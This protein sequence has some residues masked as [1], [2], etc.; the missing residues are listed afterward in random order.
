VRLFGLLVLSS[1]F[2]SEHRVQLAELAIQHRLP[3]MFIFKT[4]VEVGGLM[5]YGVD[6]AAMYRRTGALVAR[7]LKGAKPADL[8]VEQGTKFLFAVNLKTAR[9]L[10]VTLPAAILLRADEVIE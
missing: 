9:A 8:P 4:Y 1:P 10:G 5:S 7:I 3:F 6:N 2:F